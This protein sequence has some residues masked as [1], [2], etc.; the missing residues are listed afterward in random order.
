[1]ETAPLQET[2]RIHP[3]TLVLAALVV[4]LSAVPFVKNFKYNDN[5]LNWSNHDYGKNLMMCAEQDSVFMTEGG[6]N[7]V[8]STLYFMYSEKLRPD[9][10]PYDQKG[11][12]FKRIYG[13]MRY[14]DPQTLERRMNLVDTH[15]FKGE[16]PFY[17]NIRD[18]ADPY[19]IPYWQGQRPVYLTWQRPNPGSL[20]D[21]YYKRYG[22]M[23]KVQ[24]IEYSLVD[25]LELKKETTLEDARSQFAALLNRPVSASFALE[26][27]RKMER[28]GYLRLSGDTVRFVKMYPAPQKGEYLDKLL[29]RWQNIPNAKYWD[30]LTREIFINYDYQMGEIYRE[31]I[32]ELQVMRE[33]ERRPEIIREIDRRMAENW[34]LAKERYEDAIHNGSD[35]LSILHNLAVVYLRNGI[36]DLDAQAGELLGK[37][38]RYYRNSWGT[39][40]LMFSYLITDTLKHNDHETRNLLEMEK[41]MNQLKKELM[42]YR[43]SRGNYQ[44]HPVWKNFAGIENY[45]GIFRQMP[46]SQLM[47]MEQDLN[48]QLRE[49]P[50][51]VNNPAA[52]QV[53]SLLYNLGLPF[54]YQPYIDRANDLFD[55]TVRA[56]MNDPAFV[57]WAFQIALQ[58]QRTD[59][60]FQ[61]GKTYERLGPAVSDPSFYYTMG[62]VAYNM[63]NRPEARRYLTK[64]LDTV[65]DNRQLLLQLREPV[66]NSKRMLESLK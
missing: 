48:R 12:I 6:D 59:R 13:D 32:G 20:G 30:F 25:Y 22:I 56:K 61:L 15:L 37:A 26:K 34:K 41:W 38:L 60:A 17:V 49:N 29:L 14:I 45:I 23:F 66:E 27:I 28:E 4:L 64:F 62:A 31:K 63:N 19:F 24:D 35:S 58:L 7:Q 51:Q 50:A 55:R 52:Q 16:E 47:A 53:I 9:L 54:Q 39:Y 33:R 3:L 1:M 5:H 21:Y 40:S 18:R 11:N 57:G 46:V 2:E 65:G 42:H 43:S 10:S 44:N 8:F 36:E